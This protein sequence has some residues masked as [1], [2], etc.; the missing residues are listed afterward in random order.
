MTKNT[1]VYINLIFDFEKVISDNYSWQTRTTETLTTK[2][3]EQTKW[4]RKEITLKSYFYFKCS[5]KFWKGKYII[6]MMSHHGYYD[7]AVELL[8]NFYIHIQ[9]N[10]N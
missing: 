8:M 9:T 6:T 1:H 7:I 5:L 10:N 3:K 2:E 4:I